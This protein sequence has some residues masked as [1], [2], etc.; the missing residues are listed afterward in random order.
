MSLRTASLGLASALILASVAFAADE[1][2]ELWEITNAME[3]SGM[4][5]P[6]RTNQICQATNPANRQVP[7]ANDSEECKLIDSKVVGSTTRWTATCGTGEITYDGNKSFHGVMNVNH[8]GQ[9]MTMRMSGRNLG[10]ACDAGAVRKQAEAAVAQG[11]A[12]MDQSCKAAVDGMSTYTLN[13]ASGMQC[14]PKYTKQF[15][16]RLRTEAGYDKFAQQ[17]DFNA[18]PGSPMSPSTAASLCGLSVTGANS[19]DS[20]RAGLCNSALASESLNFLGR[21][22]AP[23][24]KPLAMRECAG[25]GFTTPVADKYKDF[26]TAYARHGLLAGAPPSGDDAAANPAAAAQPENK[27]DSAIKAGKKALKGL[28]GF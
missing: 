28:I 11:A 24:A 17:V 20:V 27:T 16:E 13:P 4:S 6:A 3:M 7:G 5:M 21:N 18:A 2:G 19:I 12:M 15:C 8:E 22:C 23:E 10:T 9:Q 1:P 14:D 25:R 26:C